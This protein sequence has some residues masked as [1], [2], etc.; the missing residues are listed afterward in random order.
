MKERIIAHV[1]K[2]LETYMKYVEQMYAHPE[3]GNEEFET[4]ALLADALEALGFETQRAFVCPTGFQ[5]VYQDVY[6]RQRGKRRMDLQ[7]GSSR[8]SGQMGLQRI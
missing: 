7:S 2:H 1:E 6:K 4:M 8:K 5:G 3:I